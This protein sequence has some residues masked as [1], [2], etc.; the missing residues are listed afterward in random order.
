MTYWLDGT[1]TMGPVANLSGSQ[2]GYRF[3]RSG[4][5]IV[6]LWD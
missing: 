5:T 3:Q 1:T 6:A 4:T 2:M